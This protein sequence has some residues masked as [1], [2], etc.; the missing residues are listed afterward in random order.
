[1]FI[2]KSDIRAIQEVRAGFA[3]AVAIAVANANADAAA[4]DWY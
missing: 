1:M 4:D 3:V 2:R